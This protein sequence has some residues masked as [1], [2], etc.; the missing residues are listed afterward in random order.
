MKCRPLIFHVY[1]L[2]H[3]L[4]NSISYAAQ[5][6]PPP[7]PPVNKSQLGGLLYGPALLSSD[8]VPQDSGPDDDTVPPPHRP[9]GGPSFFDSAMDGILRRAAHPRSLLV[10]ELPHLSAP[11]ND[12]DIP[13]AQAPPASAE[14][15]SSPTGV[16][17]GTLSDSTPTGVLRTITDDPEM[18]P[19]PEKPETFTVV[20]DL[21]GT[22]IAEGTHVIGI[23]QRTDLDVFFGEL[24][25]CILAGK[26]RI[27]IWTAADRTHAEPAVLLL[28]LSIPP[29]VQ[30]DLIYRGPAWFPD[31]AIFYTKDLRELKGTKGTVVLIDNNP[32]VIET[33]A[34]CGILVPTFQGFDSDPVLD[35]LKNMLFAIATHH[36]PPHRAG[37]A[38]H[39]RSSL[40]IFENTKPVKEAVLKIFYA[41]G[42]VTPSELY[43]ETYDA[44]DE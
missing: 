14:E 5:D 42:A 43:D 20:L 38:G 37:R 40:T 29:G 6:T 41:G 27:I 28:A 19:P 44:D 13:A 31:H 33:C 23:I 11:A 17:P 24:G 22:L 18:I 39:L 15:P 32:N 36:L 12:T 30:I 3:L 35:T 2:Y 21:D 34:G 7:S 16:S 8:E 9:F 4:A 10:D 25:P 1:F 26:M